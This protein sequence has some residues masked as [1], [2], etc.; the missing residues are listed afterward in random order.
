[1]YRALPV[2][3]NPRLRV[4]KSVLR[5]YIDVLHVIVN[6]KDI[7]F[8][9][10]PN[11][12]AGDAA[13]PDTPR[14]SVASEQGSQVRV[15]AASCTLLWRACSP[16]LQTRGRR[17]C[18]GRCGRHG[19]AGPLWPEQ[20][21]APQLAEQGGPHGAPGAAG[22]HLR[23]AHRVARAVHLEHGRRQKGH[24]LPALW[25]HRQGAA[26]DVVFLLP[27]LRGVFGGV[28]DERLGVCRRA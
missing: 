27:G 16:L 3:Q 5:T 26:P 12:P 15:P 6:Q 2:R 13:M 18:A 21:R 23:E 28:A 22:G 8:Q 10:T 1:M 19:H 4:V 17:A 11:L 20:P 14:S 24:P 7:I 9:G 25:R